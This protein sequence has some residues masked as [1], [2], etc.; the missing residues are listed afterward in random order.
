MILQLKSCQ[1][2]HGDLIVDNDRFGLFTT[3]I[4]FVSI[5]FNNSISPIIIPPPPKIYS[6]TCPKCYIKLSYTQPESFRRADKLNSTC[7]KC[8]PNNSN[9][10][11][12]YKKQAVLAA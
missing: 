5:V 10:F 9:Q 2:C 1:K 7:R 8:R 4:Q 12:K 11:L 6:R 3:C